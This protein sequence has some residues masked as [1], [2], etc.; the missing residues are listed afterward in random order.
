LIA[1]GVFVVNRLRGVSL[2]A[3]PASAPACT[4]TLADGRQASVNIDQAGNASLIAGVA[5]QR[6]L[7]PRATSIALT[8]AF[9]ESGLRNLDYGDLDSLGLFQQRPA[10]GWGTPD[11]IMDPYY[12]TT[13]FFDALVRIPGWDQADIGT[14]AQEVQR[15]AYPDAYDKH[16]DRARILASALTGE[17]PTAWTC[18][19]RN[20]QPADPAGL[21]QALSRTYGA[22]LAI[23]P[24]TTGGDDATAPAQLTLQAASSQAAWS[25]AA[26][27]QSWAVTYGV[28]QVQVGDLVWTGQADV[29]SGWIGQ[30]GETDSTTVV[31]MFFGP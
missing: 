15:S 2:P 6:G 16:V 22:L 7:I 29:Q 27:V 17:T 23:G 21:S 20:P 8:T 13:K 12:A 14:V 25:A 1:V 30:P 9:Q 5:S 28:H 18:H 4:A 3:L 11:Q 19:V 10:A 26:F 31:V 24:A